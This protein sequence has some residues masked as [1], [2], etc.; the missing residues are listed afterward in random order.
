[1][2]GLEAFSLACGVMQ[3]IQFAYETTKL[4][5]SIYQSGHV[6]P[7]LQGTASSLS[8]VA[9]KAQE[10]Y[11]AFAPKTDSERHLVSVAKECRRAANSLEEEVKFLND[12]AKNKTLAS[13]LRVAVKVKWRKSRLDRLEK[14]LEACRKTMETHLLVR[15][16]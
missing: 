2:S 4:C 16:W 10:H 11:E 1:M 5:R 15:V 9:G 14:S 13:T 6:H 7:E 12:G 8:F 3:T